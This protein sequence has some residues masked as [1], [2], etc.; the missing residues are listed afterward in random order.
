[1]KQMIVNEIKKQIPNSRIKHVKKDD[2]PRDYRVNFSKIS[3]VLGFKITKTVPDGIKEI[4]GFI[5]LGV[6]QN[7]EEQRYYNI[8]HKA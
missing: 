1:M 8:P 3:D 5:E 7:P 6:I 2:D 4:K